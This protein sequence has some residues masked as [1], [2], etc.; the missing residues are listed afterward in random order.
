MQ[1]IERRTVLIVDDNEAAADILG[2]LLTFRG[3]RTNIVHNGKSAL[4]ALRKCNAQVALIDIG[5]PDISGYDVARSLR[6][7]GCA[8]PL[9]AVT[10]YGQESDKQKAYQAGFD[11]HLTKPVLLAD[12]ERIFAAL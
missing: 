6:D 3:H 7:E 8:I 9:I 11:H 4:G 1:T 5:L 2:K 12:I 10:G